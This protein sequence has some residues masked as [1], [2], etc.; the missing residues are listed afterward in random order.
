MKFATY[1]MHAPYLPT[2]LMLLDGREYLKFNSKFTPEM[3][4]WNTNVVSFWGKR[5]IFRGEL[6]VLGSKYVVS[7]YH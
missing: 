1:L 7:T 6:L 3:D 4:G 5:T 2:Q